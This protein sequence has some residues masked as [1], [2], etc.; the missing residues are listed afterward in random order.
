MNQQKTSSDGFQADYG[1]LNIPENTDWATLRKHY[2]KLALKWHPDKYAEKPE[3]IEAAQTQFI[4]LA[5][6]YNNLKQFHALHSRLPFE[7]TRTEG[8][9]HGTS[10]NIQKPGASVQSN[11]DPNNL[12]LDTLC[13]DESKTDPRLVKKS[14]LKK[15]LWCSVVSSVI[16]CTV[17]IFFILDRKAG[18]KN[19]EIGRQVLK[20]APVSEFT[21]TPSQIRRGESKGTFLKIKN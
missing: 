6:S 1:I 17:L 9:R 11:V 3:Q 21:P 5:T 14:P 7:H 18:Q 16:V 10:D 13:R 2:R 8:I 12:D 19:S 15:I 4:A 20:D